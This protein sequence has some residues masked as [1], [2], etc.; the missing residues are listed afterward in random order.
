MSATTQMIQ[1]DLD[2]QN[3]VTLIDAILAHQVVAGRTPATV[4]PD[5]AASGADV[6]GDNKIGLAE[7]L[8]ILQA[9]AGVR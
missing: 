4:R 2:G 6:N 7:V 5:Y 8:Y 3:G 1:G 9:V